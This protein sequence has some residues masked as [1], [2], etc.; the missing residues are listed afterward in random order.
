MEKSGMKSDRKSSFKPQ[1]YF[2]TQ[3]A[4]DQSI[5]SQSPIF[6]HLE[7]MKTIN[8]WEGGCEA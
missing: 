8:P 2:C 7:T 3:E 6:S 4:L 1:V 5:D